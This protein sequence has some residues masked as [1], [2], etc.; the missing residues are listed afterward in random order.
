MSISDPIHNSWTIARSAILTHQHRLAVTANNIANVNTPGYSRQIVNL[1]TTPETKSSLWET[2]DFS[3]GTGVRIANVTRAQN[4]VIQSL[5]RQQ[6]GDAEAHDL[7][8]GMLGRLE[9]ILSEE[10]DGSLGAKLDAFW[11]AWYDVSNQ[12]ENIG[13]RSVAIQSGVELTSHI[14]SLN[15]R[16][17]AFEDQIITGVPGDYTGQL[18]TDVR[19]F[20]AMTEELQNLNARIS[21]SLSSFQPNALMDRRDVLLRELSAWAPVDVDSDYNVSLDGQLIVSSDG[22][23]RATLDIPDAGP[24]PEFELDGVAINIASGRLGAWSDIWAVSD[25]LRS[26]LN[27]LSAE[28]AEAINSIHNSDN[29]PDGDSFDLDGNRSDWDFFVGSTAGDIMVNPLIYD[30]A[31]PMSMDPRLLAAAASRFDD[32]PPPIPN[33]GDGAR[34]LE[35]AELSVAKRAALNGQTF[36]QFYSTGQALLGSMIQTEKGLAEDGKAIMNALKD[37][38]EAEIGVNL[39]EELMDMLSA[40]RAFQAAGRLLQTVDE[41]IMTILQMK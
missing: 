37:A 38:L 21:Y 7:R 8:A 17:L 23:T 30:P 16:M 9:A 39:D 26:R 34:A 25:A 11:N 36:S 24:P 12:S 27:D 13:F 5:L 6:A 22:S 29:N 3:K 40:Q 10:G 1:A 31:D 41:M 18:P 14:R 33:P 2:R 32:G 4:E 35:I 15:T 28:L 19:E 20:N